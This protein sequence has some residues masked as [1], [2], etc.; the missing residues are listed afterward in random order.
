MAFVPVQANEALV[1]VVEL[2]GSDVML[3]VGAGVGGGLVE[4]TS[5]TAETWAL[6][7]GPVASTTKV[8]LPGAR[9][10]Y[11][12]GL[13]QLPSWPPSSEHELDV[14]FVDAQLNDAFGD[15]VGLDGCAVSWI[16][17]GGGVPASTVQF[18]VV[19]AV[20]HLLLTFSTKE[21]GPSG[22]SEY[23]MGL[24]HSAGGAPSREHDWSYGTFATQLKSA[25]EAVVVEDG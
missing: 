9:L 15:V 12:F 18:T 11:D 21:W 5:Q 19:V 1:A 22:R 7:P 8:C 23:V 2:D 13:A 25:T 17:G 10:L 4:T 3:T 24:S 14:V 6:P 20:P 16:V